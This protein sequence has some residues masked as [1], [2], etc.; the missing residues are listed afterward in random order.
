MRVDPKSLSTGRNGCG[1]QSRK[2]ELISAAIPLHREADRLSADVFQSARADLRSSRVLRQLAQ[3][4][5]ECNAVLSSWIST[6]SLRSDRLTELKAHSPLFNEVI[7][8]FL[9]KT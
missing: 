6:Q 4:C 5:G 3:K 1:N 2:A 9:Q 7:G 8:N